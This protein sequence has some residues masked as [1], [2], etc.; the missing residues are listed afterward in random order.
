MEKLL[1]KLLVKLLMKLLEKLLVKSL[2]GCFLANF[3]FSI[4]V[5]G[6]LV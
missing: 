3:R 4:G 2:S 5:A 6:I 1:I